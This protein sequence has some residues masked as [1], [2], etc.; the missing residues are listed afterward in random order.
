MNSS[1]PRAPASEKSLAA[2]KSLFPRLAYSSA[3]AQQFMSDEL[4]GLAREAY[5]RQGTRAF[6]NTN[7]ATAYHEA[8]HVIISILSG[9]TVRR[10]WIKRKRLGGVKVWIGRTFDGAPNGSAPDSPVEADVV[11][12]RNVVAGW[13]AEIRF[14]GSDFRIGSSLD[15]IVRV[16]AIAHNIAIKT[17]LPFENVTMGI[18]EGVFADLDCHSAEVEAIAKE[19]MNCGELRRP[20]IEKLTKKMRRRS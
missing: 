16:K 13:V 3:E 17:G 6:E 7:R 15:E 8:G 10:T 9:R 20:S 2:F 12:A 19:L 4:R 11:T 1:D 14:D 5:A 18:I